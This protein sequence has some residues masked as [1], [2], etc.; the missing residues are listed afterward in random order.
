MSSIKNYPELSLIVPLYNE[1]LCLEENIATMLA[2]LERSSISHEMVLV[3]D[4]SAD[5]TETACKR[6][7]A[8][9]RAIRVISSAVNRGKG[10]AVKTGMLQAQGKYAVFTDADLA[11]PVQFLL[12]LW[13][14]LR[15]GA[16]IVIGSRHLP[17]SSFEIREGFLR[18]FFGEIFRR[19]ATLT[20]G[21]KVTDITCGFKG[22]NRTVAFDIFSR[23]K[24]ER[25]G[26]DAEILFLAQKLH[27]PVFEM[28]VNWFHSF[29]SKVNVGIDS[30]RTIS[31]M[32]RI[33]HYY[34]TKRYE[35]NSPSIKV[36]RVYGQ[37][38][39]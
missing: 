7:S 38:S 10:W 1:A 11:A 37:P 9:N 16:S 12:P 17:E 22:F 3:N 13:E 24:I 36:P 18:R 14:Q 20:L 26:Y 5:A 6:L 34:R 2:Y 8:N 27:Y 23:S 35:L 31:E 29:D 21:L 25:W 32:L 33:G 28:P 30:L 19:F 15:G 4:G 39:R